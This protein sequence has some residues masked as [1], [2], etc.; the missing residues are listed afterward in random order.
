MAG[1]IKNYPADNYS[2][3]KIIATNIKIL[4]RYD[5]D[6]LPHTNYAEWRAAL[7]DG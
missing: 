6:T 4:N 3:T 7:G 1:K 5:N 2:D